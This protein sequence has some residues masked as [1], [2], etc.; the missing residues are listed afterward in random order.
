M[1]KATHPIV[2]QDDQIR[3]RHLR[4]QEGDEPVY[5][6]SEFTVSNCLK[7][8]ATNERRLVYVGNFFTIFPMQPEISGE[9]FIISE[10]LIE[11]HGSFMTDMNIKPIDFWKIKDKFPSLEDFFETDV[12]LNSTNNLNFLCCHVKRSQV[13]D[14]F[15][16]VKENIKQ[17]LYQ[18]DRPSLEITPLFAKNVQ[19]ND[20]WKYIIKFSKAVDTTV[21]R[22]KDQLVA[23]LDQQLDLNSV[24]NRIDCYRFL[25]FTII[26]Q[27][28][29]RTVVGKLLNGLKSVDSELAT[30]FEQCLSQYFCQLID[31]V[32]AQASTDAVIKYRRR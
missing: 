2:F 12:F 27:W 24:D 20:H 1:Y 8:D 23:L 31:N 18:I 16:Q 5:D 17:R 28:L 6:F 21:K 32:I 4:W 22:H 10:P 29:P 26:P 13:D 7:F 25:K 14:C 3:V 15:L 11:S 30:N 19:N 9:H